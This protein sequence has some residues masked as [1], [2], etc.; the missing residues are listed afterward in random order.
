MKSL[1]EFKK[2]SIKITS[3]K[4]EW[5]DLYKVLIE[6]FIEWNI[7]DRVSTFEFEWNSKFGIIDD[8]FEPIFIK[9]L[10]IHV[11]DIPDIPIW[12]NIFTIKS[13]SYTQSYHGSLSN[14]IVTEYWMDLKSKDDALKSLNSE[15]VFNNYSSVSDFMNQYNKLYIRLFDIA[16][17]FPIKVIYV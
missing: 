11:L 15:W 12:D 1:L 10:I 2:E 13:N 17:L 7:E 9:K 4:K 5:E 16:R 14:S 3:P 8:K 6:K